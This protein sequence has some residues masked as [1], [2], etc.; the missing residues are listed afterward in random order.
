MDVKELDWQVA[1]FDYVCVCRTHSTHGT[2]HARHTHAQQ[3]RTQRALLHCAHPEVGCAAE[4]GCA[5]CQKGSNRHR[6]RG[7]VYSVCAA[8]SSAL[9]STFTIGRRLEQGHCECL[10]RSHITAGSSFRGAVFRLELSIVSRQS[11]STLAPRMLFRRSEV[12][13]RSQVRR[14]GV[15]GR[16]G[17]RGVPKGVQQASI[18]AAIS[19][20]LIEYSSAL[21]EYSPSGRRLEQGA[22]SRVGGA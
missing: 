4:V 12:R 8:I 13:G 18:Y 2:S 21:I 19:S 3:A 16:S 9:L 1:L 14:S 11:N 20:V 7:A 22:P 17:V 6:Y 10:L 5:V 15:C